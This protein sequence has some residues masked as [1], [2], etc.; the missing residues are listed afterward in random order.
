MKTSQRR[1]S[2]LALLGACLA[3]SIAAAQKPVIDAP[4]TARFGAIDI[5]MHL[6]TAM[7]LSCN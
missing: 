7:G 1:V 6:A 3:P 5:S 4:Q 2:V